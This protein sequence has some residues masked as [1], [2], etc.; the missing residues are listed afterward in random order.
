MTP[1]YD[2]DWDPLILGLLLS[3]QL[4]C[5]Q[6]ESVGSVLSLLPFLNSCARTSSW[7][8]DPTKF[9][10]EISRLTCVAPSGRPM[11][12]PLLLT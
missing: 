10:K 8:S 7:G 2:L 12:L 1:K 9:S 3:G 4:A 11:F 6:E 5:S